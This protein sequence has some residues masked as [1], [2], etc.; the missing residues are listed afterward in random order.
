MAAPVCRRTKNAPSDPPRVRPGLDRVKASAVVAAALVAIGAAAI[1][2]VFG[3]A[4]SGL[5]PR[6]QP[7]L[8]RSRQPMP[9]IAVIRQTSDSWRA[10]SGYR[11]YS[12][13]IVGLALARDAAREPGR[14]LVYFSG[15]DVNTQWNTGVPYAE[16]RRRG[17]LLKDRA[18]NLLVNRGYPTN[19]VGDVGSRSYQQAWLE[20]VTRLLRRN[21]DD[22]VFIDDVIMDL[23][24]L[25]GTE[26]AKYPTAE[27]WAD[28]ELSFT[29]AVGDG[30]RSEGYYVLVNASAFVRGSHASNDGSSTVSWW[31]R[32]GPHVS[33]LSVEYFQ[34]TPDGQDTLRTSG[35][36]WY[37]SWS[38]WE[39]LVA[40]AQSLGKDFFGFMYG[41]AND[42]R[43]MSYG[44]ASFLLG[45]NGGGGA[46]VYQP[47]EKH[48]PWNGAWTSDI[49]RPEAPKR[50]IGTAW[51]RRYSGGVAIVNPDPSRAQRLALGRG[52]LSP[53]GST[54][55]QVTVPP[56]TGL[57]LRR[58]AP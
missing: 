22:G 35:S 2:A 6:S 4:P 14:S 36:A 12:D 3:R 17:W 23:A 8:P 53:D 43:R 48:D 33:G 25:A 11:S 56:T 15:T 13:L 40:T 27:E 7:F 16:A 50:R 57:V 31:R 30:L 5:Q 1:Y 47:R 26:A 18:G 38:G 20:N 9:G 45:W 55:S 28:A 34:E 54:I 21:G 39:R 29:R 19:Y 58:A 51:L 32:L 46:F 10:A 42:A 37:Q 52:Y 24:P 49:G 41:P 44:K